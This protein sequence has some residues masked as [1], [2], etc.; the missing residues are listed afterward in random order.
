[1]TTPEMVRACVQTAGTAFGSVFVVLAV[2]YVLIRLLS[3]GETPAPGQAD[4]DA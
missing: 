4:P 3:R 1:M 2:F